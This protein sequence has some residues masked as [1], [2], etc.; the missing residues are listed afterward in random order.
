VRW[1]ARGLATAATAVALVAILEAAGLR[2][3]SSNV[4]RPGS[5]LG[6]AS[7]EGAFAILAVGPLVA[8]GRSRRD[9][10]VW[11]GAGAGAVTAVLSASRGALVGLVV[12][13]VVLA[14]ARRD[15][16]TRGVLAAGVA[17][18]AI[19]VL[20]L[21]QVRHRA[22]GES[23]LAGHTT[24]GR[25]LLWQETIH[26]IADRPLI[27]VG[28]SGF[29]DAVVAQHDRHWQRVV[30]PAD[31]PDSPHDWVLQAAT[32]GGIPLALLAVAG[33]AY[34]ARR[35]RLAVVAEREV[36]APPLAAGLA[37]GLCGYLVALLVHLT[38]PGPTV[39]A[40]VFAGAL[41]AE[42]AT[43]GSER[44]TARFAIPGVAAVLAVFQLVSAIAEIPL[45]TAV[46]D[47]TDGNLAGAK[48][49]FDTA[50]LLR[51][52]DVE[53]PLAAGH[54]FAA[55]S[56]AGD[57]GAPA[58]GRPWLDDA[59]R[60]VPTSEQAREDLAVVEAASGDLGGAQRLLDEAITRDRFNPEL[61][62]RRGV[63]E[64][65]QHSFA[66]AERDLLDAAGIANRSPQPWQDLATLYTLERRSADAQRAQAEAV[67]RG[68]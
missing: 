20:I 42:S 2:P 16:V 37:A 49:S 30:G 31:P 39:V 50:K 15:R 44:R 6:N 12:V 65:Q 33:A 43:A 56:L 63:V 8:I 51:P 24:S 60:R 47:V 62:L 21:P 53:I 4:A 40:A 1:L 45:R 29:E 41:V 34:V 14:L 38:A 13:A 22:L 17:T 58:Y 57:E 27:G 5:L 28:P 23:S 66:A 26:L 48:S 18:L 55:V 35:S 46:V 9:P 36:R 68:G 11:L 32:T 3:L 61:L 10:L 67:R 64:A 7:D 25:V 54:A 19:L 59:L 52:W